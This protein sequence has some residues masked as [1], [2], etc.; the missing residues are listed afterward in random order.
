MSE[1]FER[2]QQHGREQG[3]RTAL[4]SYRR[5]KFTSTS[6]DELAAGARAFARAFGTR[7]P[8]GQIIPML[9]AR[10]P[11]CVA[12][13]SG[14]L[15]AGC[16]FSCV[17]QKL[18]P[19]QIERI[20]SETNAP[21]ALVDGPG[22]MAL[23][24]AI[25]PDS[26]IARTEWWLVRGERFGKSHERIAEKLAAVARVEDW[27]PTRWQDEES[28]SVREVEHDEV[29]CCLFTSGSTGTPK[30]VLISHSDL[31]ARAKAEATWFE[32]R[33]DDALLCLLPFSFDVG[34]NQLISLLWTGCELSL[35]D[36]W[37]SKDVMMAVETRKATGISAV[38][39]IWQDFLTKGHAFDTE[40]V[41]ASLRYLTVSGGDLSRRDLERLPGLAKGVG[42]FKT[43]GQTEAFRGA[44]LRPAEFAARPQSV[45]RAFHGARVY[46]V[47]DDGT[48]AE[49]N[50]TGEVVLTGL[51]VM[52]G[53]LDA[54]D[55]ENKLRPNPFR[56]DEDESV[57]SIFTGDQGHLDEEG[58]LHLEGRRDDMVKVQGNRVYPNEVR[59]QVLAVEGIAQAEV[60]PVKAA[61]DTRLVAFIVAGQSEL[62]SDSEITMQLGA[63]VPSYMIPT[64]FVAKPRL[65]LTASGKPDRPLLKAEATALLESEPPNV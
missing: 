19:P 12:A 46:I 15:G 29:A 62:P 58:F 43:Y 14:A 36:S 13:M 60:I 39:S 51:G 10:T 50:E 48:R 45:G 65:P 18:R 1:L 26:P 21:V 17:N 64:R 22:L 25:S 35:L 5:G 32:L 34:L 41:H 57:M 47:R 9:L 54:R 38:P 11:E 27:D 23:K 20:L 30:G 63:L 16:A 6:Y 4:W 37:F 7:L 44:S 61:D 2:L 49:A 40:G 8:R 56:G 33:R 31:V 59:E 52:L 42:I 55:P 24:A 28:S 53:Y 3:E